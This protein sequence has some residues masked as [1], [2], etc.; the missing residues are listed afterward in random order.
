MEIVNACLRI[1]H[2]CKYQA[3]DDGAINSFKF[4]ALE[5]PRGY[6][7]HFLGEPALNFQPWEYG[8]QH[9]KSTDI[10][11]HFKIP[12]KSPVELS[13]DQKRLGILNLQGLPELP[14]DYVIPPGTTR[15]AARRAITPPGFAQAFFKAN[16]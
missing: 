10:W 13:E 16:T 4:W 3:W 12:Q 11:G 5:N 2:E 6:L 8:D 9:S 14:E 7:R 15:R 1:I